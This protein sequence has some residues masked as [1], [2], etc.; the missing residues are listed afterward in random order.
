MGVPGWLNL[1]TTDGWGM[2]ISTLIMMANLM[3]DDGKPD[4]KV[5]FTLM[6]NGITGPDGT[7][8]RCI[9]TECSDYPMC[10]RSRQAALEAL[11]HHDKPKRHWWHWWNRV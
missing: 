10:H 5:C 9:S 11:E 1:L 8:A 6:S 4:G 3:T 7:P 2:K